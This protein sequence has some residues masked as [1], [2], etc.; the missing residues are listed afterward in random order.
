MNNNIQ[1]FRYTV[2]WWKGQEYCIPN[3]CKKSIRRKPW[4]CW[5]S[6]KRATQ[7]QHCPTLSSRWE[8]NEAPF[9]VLYLLLFFS[10]RPLENCLISNIWYC[11]RNL[12][13]I[14]SNWFSRKFLY[15]RVIII[16]QTALYYCTISRFKQIINELLIVI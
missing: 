15:N 16:Y 14:Y 11:C 3:S 9:D 6:L 12:Q 10:T 4:K 13:G 1:Y 8:A 5:K 7:G 2:L